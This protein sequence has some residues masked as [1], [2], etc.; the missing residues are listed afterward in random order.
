MPPGRFARR[1]KRW[2]RLRRDRS[3]LSHSELFDADWYLA[4][5]P[6][7]A[8]AGQ[9]PLYHFLA[10][11]AAEGRH[12]GPLFDTRR[13]LAD[14]RDVAAAG[15][16]PLI[17]YLLHGRAEGR[18]AT[19]VGAFSLFEAR[20]EL[21]PL[22]LCYTKAHAR[23]LTIV[24]DSTSPAQLFG[25]VMTSII[26]GALLAER[27][28]AHLRL[29]T[30]SQEPDLTR[31]GDVLR[32]SGLGD[33]PEMSAVRLRPGTT[34]SLAETTDSDVYLTTSWW[35]TR[36]TLGSVPA[37]QV[38][39]LLQ[40][41][42][43]LFYPDGDS[44]LR[45]QE[46][47]DEPELTY[48]VN[49]ELLFDHFAQNGAANVV[50]S[51]FYFE[52]AFP[53]ALFHPQ[54]RASEKKRFAFYARPKNDRN[55]YNRGVEVISEALQRGILS[56]Q[57]WEIFFVGSIQDTVVLPGSVRPITKSGLLLTE[58]AALIGSMDLGLALMSS[59]HPSYPPLD[60]AAAGA[61]AV[62]TTYG[63]KRDLSRY[64]ANLLVGPPTVKRLTELL[65]EGVAL[66]A[67]LP[68]RRAN[69]QASALARDWRATTLPLIDWLSERLARVV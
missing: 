26:V 29:I 32:S 6:D 28:G 24:T 56:P 69:H 17:H 19:P 43:R 50:R 35:T 37:S 52:P 13:Y 38:V 21:T 2:W 7:V 45:C 61:V 49:T 41:D 15:E 51:G 54:P 57:E 1:V 3:L 59:P 11:G 36:A 14:N 55:L 67:D 48:A 9:N 66:A 63:C 60:L 65:A 58:Y 8:A 40:E 31:I 33:A 34:V 16:N 64:S 39:F 25:G 22:P 62:T 47:L 23:R 10:H 4:T 53:A 46:T 5:Y 30:R 42:E 18:A 27:M 68:R 12:P 20:P 44:R